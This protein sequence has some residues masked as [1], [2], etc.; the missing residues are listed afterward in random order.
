MS[1]NI[2]GI[3]RAV[4]ANGNVAYWTGR[5]GAKWVSANRALAFSAYTMEGARRKALQ[6]NRM[7]DIHGWRFIAVP[8]DRDHSHTH[9][10]DDAGRCRACGE[11]A[12]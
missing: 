4:D 11:F 6:F 1:N 9:D 8:R 2:F 5:T 3:L 10:L 12:V 7:S